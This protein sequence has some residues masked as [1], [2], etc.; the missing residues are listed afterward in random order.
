M[1][2]A[3]YYAFSAFFFADMALSIAEHSRWG[4]AIDLGLAVYFLA[5]ALKNE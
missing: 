2:K 3:A 1:S 4:V 5:R